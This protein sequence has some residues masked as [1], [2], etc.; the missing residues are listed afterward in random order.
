VSPHNDDGSFAI[1]SERLAGVEAHHFVV[2]PTDFGLWYCAG[3]TSQAFQGCPPDGL[4]SDLKFSE[5]PE[6]SAFGMASTRVPLDR[7]H[8]KLSA[9]FTTVH[10]GSTH[11]IRAR[12]DLF[13]MSLSR[14]K[15]KQSHPR[16]I[17]RTYISIDLSRRHDLLCIV[18]QV[19]AYSYPSTL[20]RAVCCR[21]V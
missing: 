21:G 15:V 7:V 8:C 9:R 3:G 14:F 2:P 20:A 19:L 4:S 18:L 11:A 13:A 16:T 12:D 6:H 17:L 5:H 10:L 1:G